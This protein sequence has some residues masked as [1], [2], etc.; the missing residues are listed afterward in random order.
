M[1]SN[2]IKCVT[3]FSCFLF[4]Q[5]TKTLEQWK[6][7]LKNDITE[8]YYMACA[9]GCYNTH[10]D[11]LILVKTRN[12]RGSIKGLLKQS[13]KQTNEQTNKQKNAHSSRHRP[14]KIYTV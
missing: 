5:E 14:D 9:C 1:L 8:L 13:K 7:R 2:E 10:S 12:T 6:S 3:S 4:H 11:W